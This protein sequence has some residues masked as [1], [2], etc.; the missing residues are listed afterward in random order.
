MGHHSNNPGPLISTLHEAIEK[1]R[2]GGNLNTDTIK[3]FML[4]DPKFALLL[5][6]LE[7]V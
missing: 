3:Y 6:A 2:K 4:K 7:N 5:L 1:I